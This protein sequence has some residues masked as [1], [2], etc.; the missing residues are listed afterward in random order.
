M[1]LPPLFELHECA[2]DFAAYV[3]RVYA[4]FCAD[5]SFGHRP[6]FDGK[7]LIVDWTLIDG[8]CKRFWH[9]VSEGQIEDARTISLERCAR[10]TWVRYMIDNRASGEFAYWRTG[11]RLLIATREFDYLVVLEG[12]KK[13]VILLTAYLVE[14]QNRRDQ[15]RRQY[16]QADERF[17]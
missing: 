6:K 2:G 7:P 9:M 14:H 8:K 16:E 17:S 13:V 10:L 11:T 3:D 1:P 4:A 5:F 15:L 12:Q